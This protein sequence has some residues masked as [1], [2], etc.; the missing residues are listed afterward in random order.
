MCRAALRQPE[1]RQ[2]DPEHPE[3]EQPELE[4]PGPK[5]VRLLELHQR[6]QCH[7]P[8]VNQRRAEQPDPQGRQHWP[9]PV[10]PGPKPGQN[11]RACLLWLPQ[12]QKPAQMQGQKQM[13]RP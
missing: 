7:A 12:G 9:G 3:L 2:P 4:Q 13:Q 1:L 5:P 8:G 6:P 10:R 11:Q